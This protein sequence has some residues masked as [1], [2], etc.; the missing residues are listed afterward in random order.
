MG[1]GKA[2]L[3]C[4]SHSVTF[5]PPRLATLRNVV[6][7]GYTLSKHG[8]AINSCMWTMRACVRVCICPPVDW[9]SPNLEEK[10][11]WLPQVRWAYILFVCA[12][13][14]STWHAHVPCVCVSSLFH[15]LSPNLVGTFLG[16][17]HRYNSVVGVFHVART[18]DSNSMLWFIQG[19]VR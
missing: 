16:S 14:I 8:T 3:L 1:I 13:M 6:E 19:S 2:Y 10:F 18:M 5:W 11:D 7:H 17:P 4:P 15:E 9:Y 12:L